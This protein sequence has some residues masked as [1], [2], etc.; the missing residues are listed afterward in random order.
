[1]KKIMIMLALAALPFLYLMSAAIDGAAQVKSKTVQVPQGKTFVKLD[2]T[3]K[4]VAR[5]SS[6]RSMGITDCAQVP[7]PGTFDKDI[8]C[9][10]CVER[11]SIR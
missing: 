1:M 11:S 3:G 4:I 9:W 5:F 10:K 6:G 7:C 8:V 2:Q